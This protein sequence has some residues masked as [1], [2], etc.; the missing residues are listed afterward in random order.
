M[1]T[2]KTI[3]LYIQTAEE[4]VDLKMQGVTTSDQSAVISKLFLFLNRREAVQAPPKEFEFK[5]LVEG[6]Y[7]DKKATEIIKEL[8]PGQ[9][10]QK[11][12]RPRRLPFVDREHSNIVSVGEALQKA[13]AKKSEVPSWWYT[14]IKVAGDGTNTYRCY[15]KCPSCGDK[16]K[17]Y[18]PLDTKTIQCRNCEAELKVVTAVGMWDATGIPVRDTWGNFFIANE[19]AEDEAEDD[20]QE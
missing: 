15:Y 6:R 7:K 3:E 4:K 12:S 16:G 9:E 2:P 18:I 5:P 1:K 14:G 20:D 8:M 13:V 11:E 10:G 19:L 17:R